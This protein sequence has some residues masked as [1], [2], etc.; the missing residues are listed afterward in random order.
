MAGTASSSPAKVLAA[1]MAH[2]ITVISDIAG[3]PQAFLGS[4]CVPYARPGGAVCAGGASAAGPATL[5][6]RHAILLTFVVD[7]DGN[8]F[9]WHDDLFAARAE[10]SLEHFVG[11]DSIVYGFA[12]HDTALGLPVVRLFDACRLRGRSLLGLTCFERFG[13]LFE[14]V[15]AVSRSRASVVRMHWVWTEGWLDEFVLRKPD[16]AL[17]GMDCEWEYAI[18]LPELLAPDACFHALETA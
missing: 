18:R 12:Y 2:K 3:C 13:A 15:S 5:F 14:G 7:R 11:A 6:P 17:H 10:Y 16:E 1:V 8:T 9:L 4:E